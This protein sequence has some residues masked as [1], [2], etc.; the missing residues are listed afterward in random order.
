MK[1]VLIICLASVFL[2]TGVIMAVMFNSSMSYD[3]IEGKWQFIEE[4]GDDWKVIHTFM[5]DGNNFTLESEH[6][7][8]TVINLGFE[9]ITETTK[10]TF[11]ITGNYLTGHEIE[12]RFLESVG[13]TMLDYVIEVSES[14]AEHEFV[15]STILSSIS[16]R[17]DSFMLSFTNQKFIRVSS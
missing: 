11:G 4:A 12:I 16:V 15:E 10:G 1:K 6:F 7:T 14:G 17:K 8:P 2:I 9:S 3:K 13:K 5:F